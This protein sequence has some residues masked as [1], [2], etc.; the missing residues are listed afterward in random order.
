MSGEILRLVAVTSVGFKMLNIVLHEPEIPANT[1]NIGRTCCATGTRLHL[2]EPLGFV[3][4]DKTVKRAGMDYWDRL[5]V[6]RYDDWD[7]F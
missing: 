6:F 1:G 4:T 3:L 2:I 5:E 7:D